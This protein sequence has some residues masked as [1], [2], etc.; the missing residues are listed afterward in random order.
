MIRR[1]SAQL[2]LGVLLGVTAMQLSG[3]GATIKPD[4][5]AQSV[6][7]IVSEQTGF[8][9]TD[10]SCPSGV[11]A[12]VGGEF[13]CHFTGPEGKPYTADMKI[14]KVD[15]ERVEFDTKTHPS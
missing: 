3:C 5:A 15:G 8:R 12:K 13:T 10:V 7:D 14:T 6:V 4:G 2:C 1:I 9:P 11:D